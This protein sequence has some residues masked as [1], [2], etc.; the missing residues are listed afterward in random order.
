MKIVY[1]YSYLGGSEILTVKYPHIDKDI[2]EVIHHINVQHTIM[3]KKTGQS[4]L[5]Y[6]PKVMNSQFMEAFR[7][8]GFSEIKD[9]YTISIP[10]SDVQIKGVSKQVNFIK[11]RV[12]VEVQFGPPAFMFYDMAKFHYFF[13]EGK[14]DVGVEIIPCHALQSKMSSDVSY[15]EQLVD[16]IERLKGNFLTV[17]MKVVLVDI[18]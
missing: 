13:N 5:L 10:E 8:R 15:G 3:K 6:D 2:Q 1:E 7:A 14:A 17:P 12:L 9:T 4:K 11:E 16:D 18:D